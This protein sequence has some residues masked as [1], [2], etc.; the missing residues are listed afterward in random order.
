MNA[1]WYQLIIVM[2]IATICF[3]AYQQFHVSK[4]D[5]NNISLNIEEVQTHIEK[6]FATKAE[7]FADEGVVKVSFPRKDINVTINQWPLHPFMG[8]TS[9]V[10]FQKGSKQGVE[11]MAMGDLALLEHEV[12]HVMSVALDNGINITAL[13]NHFFYDNPKIYFM[14]IEAEGSLVSIVK[15]IH[16]MLQEISN[17]P[18]PQKLLLPTEHAISGDPIEKIMSVK[19]TEKD[20]MFKI[21]IGRQIQAGC[22]CTVRKNMGI[23]SW[24]AFGGCDDNAIVDGDFSLF[25]NEVQ[26]V[27]KAF[28]KAHI[29]VVAIHNHMLYEK[30]RMIFVHFYGQGKAVDLAH[31]IKEALDQTSMLD[32]NKK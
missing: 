23:N 12:N 5:E 6:I 18:M 13:H 22:G 2:C 8:L 10:S 1:T 15:G 17:V 14:H 3:I 28:R 4:L 25:E 19:G 20:G 32:T 24:A 30:P 7:F 16:L 11:I 29:N 9:W 27:L 26:L 31:S 21:V